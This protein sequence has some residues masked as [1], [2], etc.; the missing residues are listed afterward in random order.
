MVDDGLRRGRL[1]LQASTS[2]V[3]FR[4]LLAADLVASVFDSSRGRDR[5]E[6][7]ARASSALDIPRE[8]PSRLPIDVIAAVLASSVEPRT[9]RIAAARLARSVAIAAALLVLIGTL[10]AI[11]RAAPGARRHGTLPAPLAPLEG[12]HRR[13]PPG[14]GRRHRRSHPRPRPRRLASS[15]SPSPILRTP[16]CRPSGAARSSLDWVRPRAEALTDECGLVGGWRSRDSEAGGSSGSGDPGTAAGAPAPM[17]AD[18]SGGGRSPTNVVE[19]GV[20]EPDE[21]KLTDRALLVLNR[22]PA[23]DKHLR[24]VS[25]AGGGASV[26]ASGASSLSATRSLLVHEQTAVILG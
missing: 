4:A 19:L 24:I 9:A 8:V 20:D 11:S 1:R 10:A 17:V 12:R 3:S 22:S 13:A 15:R 16:G 5:A 26:S 21:V 25:T 6:A 7:P 14:P 2:P 18:M 23:G